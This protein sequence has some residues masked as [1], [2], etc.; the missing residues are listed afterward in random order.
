MSTGPTGIAGP[1]GIQG[2]RGSTGPTG[3]TGM[4]GPFGMQGT[5][6][7]TGERGPRGPLGIPVRPVVQTFYVSTGRI[8]PSGTN[9]TITHLFDD[10][11]PRLID[12]NIQNVPG[13]FVNTVDLGGSTFASHITVPEGDYFVQGHGTTGSSSIPSSFLR[14]SV[15]NG[16]T[17]TTDLLTGTQGGQGPTTLSLS[18]FFTV[19]SSTVFGLRQ[20]STSGGV[21]IAQV[22]GYPYIFLTLIKLR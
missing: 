5:F 7:P 18:G 12:P 2:T 8:A 14:L 10:G 15:Y 20:T 4:A 21:E 22:A 19:E 3:S 17:Y 16:T 13:F 11:Y 9:L 6:G 1:S